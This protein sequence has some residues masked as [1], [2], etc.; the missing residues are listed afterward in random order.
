MAYKVLMSID[1]KQL[2]RYVTAQINNCFDD[3]Q[4]LHED[5]VIAL[6]P[7]VLLKI[8]HCF[9]H[10]DNK[11]FFD[12]SSAVFNHL[13][14]D[15][16]AMFLYLLSNTAYKMQGSLA[17]ATKLYL[18]NKSL[19]AIDA[20]YEVDLPSIF[21]F[22]HPVGTVL[23]RADY[24]DFFLVYQRCTVG[25]NHDIYPILGPYTSLRPG[26]SILGKCTLGRNNTLA[27]ESLLLDRDL[28]N[29]SIYMGNPRN[30]E[31]K[32]AIEIPPVWK[33]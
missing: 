3:G 32:I 1:Y 22:V 16:Y 14:S 31:I 21:L 30:F 13:N 9:A 11:Y 17:L 24:S 18:L 19:H 28:V 6:L 26:S 23:G 27:A 15:Q 20:F 8:E 10:I 29:N 4:R 5:E 7:E 12:G 33:C 25:S 2:A